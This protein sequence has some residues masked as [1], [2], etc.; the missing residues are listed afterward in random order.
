M[1]K[2]KAVIDTNVVFAGLYSSIGSS[3]KILRLIEEGE[4]VPYLSTSLLFE[5]EEILL[6]NQKELKL[7]S[8]D[9][10]NTLNG[11]CKMSEHRKIHFLWRPQLSDPKDDHILELAVACNNADIV[12][13]NIKDFAQASR[14]GIRIIKPK[15]LLEELL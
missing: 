13:F 7:T 15:Q 10:E 1:I 12:T 2:Y 14:F 6:A 5:Y 4:I 9:I 8:E 3:H 11:I